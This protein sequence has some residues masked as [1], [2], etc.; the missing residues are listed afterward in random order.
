MQAK[1]LKGGQELI[2]MNVDKV[3]D[4][5]VT[6]SNFDVTHDFVF[7]GVEGLSEEDIDSV[8]CD[9]EPAEEDPVM[10]LERDDRPFMID[11][12]P[13]VLQQV[14]IQKTFV[15][16][17]TVTLTNG[18]VITSEEEFTRCEQVILCAPEGTDIDVTFTDLDC[19]I[20][21]PGE[22]EISDGVLALCG[23]SLT[24]SVCQSIQSTFPVTVEFLAEF[25]EPR[26]ILPTP[27]P[28]PTIPPQCPSIFPNGGSMDSSSHKE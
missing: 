16:T 1:D 5:I 25:C 17:V 7:P 3:Y 22:A 6:E 13:V 24:V 19:F 15:V 8:M 12:D 9:V 2:C 27:C 28:E 11:G 21:T 10:I 20:C 14:V 4:W 26:D 23:L 18:N